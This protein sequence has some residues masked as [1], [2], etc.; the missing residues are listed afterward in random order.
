MKFDFCVG[1]PAYQDTSI[2]DN[3]AFMPPVYDKF[4]DSAFSIA[5]KVEMIHPAR[6]LCNAGST[7]KAWNEKMLNDE[8]F[9]VICYEENA[10]NIFPNTDIKGGVAI[11]YH[12]NTQRFGAIHVFTKYAELN[13]VLQKAG[14]QSETDSLASIMFNQT[15]FNLDELYKDHP[16][17]KEII[18][19]GGKDKRFRN[20]IFEK[21]DL[22]VDEKRDDLIDVF[23]VIKNKRVWKY[24]PLKYVD[25]EHENL[26]KWKVLIARVN[27]VGSLG[28]TLSTPIIASPGIGYT[29]TFI[30]IGA[31]DTQAE[32]ENALKYIKT[33][34]ARTML[35]IL[36][37]T[38]D[39]SIETW[40]YVPLQ[41]FSNHS[42]INWKTTI[43]NI[44]RQLYQKYRLTE[45]EIKFIEAT[46]KEMV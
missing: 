2:G 40:R 12:D 18:G 22:F 23:G 27:G 1:N 3:A 35:G 42:D 41:N 20:N 10:A 21:I 19:S 26:Y 25:T 4:L 44:D 45:K 30:G 6:F 43:M 38:Q 14:P 29:Q 28:E 15:R 24:F 33:K 9:K 17:Y 32:A 7:P 16:E 46:A 34:F 36:K 13:S 5:D 8:H 31:F 37:I 11:T 39:N